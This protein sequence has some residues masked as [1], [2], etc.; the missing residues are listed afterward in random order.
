MD[1]R[2]FVYAMAA[3]MASGVPVSH[4]SMAAARLDRIGLELYAVRDAMQRDP[5]RTLAQVREI[6]YRDVELLWSMDNFGRTPRQVRATLDQ[7]GLRAPSAHIAPEALVDGWERS[8]DTA[9]LLGHE[10]LIVPTLPPDTERSLDRWRYWADQFNRAGAAARKAGIWLAFHN[11]P[12]HLKPIE[13]EIPY[14]V[15]VERTHPAAVR[16]QLDVGNM[17]LG[18][19]D[20][21][22]YFE[23]YRDRYWS[24]HIK[25][26]VS[27]RS[28]D[29]ELGKGIVDVRRLLSEVP[30]LAAKPVYV[31][32]EQWADS[33]ASARANYEYLRALD[34]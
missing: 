1:R 6:G 8:L 13:G 12:D 29:V 17:A 20:P 22:E 11:E 10:Y 24:F 31:E 33:I 14:E 25:D 9:K 16:H 27:D 30:G 26:V 15:F 19:A 3:S 18:G 21:L 34:F 23:K 5:E 28:R 4:R 7:E 2:S 32:Q